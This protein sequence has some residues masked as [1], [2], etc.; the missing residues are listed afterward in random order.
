MMLLRGTTRK[1]KT[2]LGLCLPADLPGIAIVSLWE[3]EVIVSESEVLHRIWYP[4]V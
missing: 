1:N 2:M 3:G 4:N